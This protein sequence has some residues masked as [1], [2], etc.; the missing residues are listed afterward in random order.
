MIDLLLKQQILPLHSYNLS[1]HQHAL[2]VPLIDTVEELGLN[3]FFFFNNFFKY[4]LLFFPFHNNLLHVFQEDQIIA[5]LVDHI[6][7]SGIKKMSI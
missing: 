1:F 2:D 3:F 6:M 7:E 4:F 5:I